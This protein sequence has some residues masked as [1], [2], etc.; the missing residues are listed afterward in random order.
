M[1]FNDTGTVLVTTAA[2]DS[3]NPVSFT[4]PY[5]FERARFDCTSGTPVSPSDFTCSVVDESDPLGS[6]IP[7]SQRPACQVTVT[8]FP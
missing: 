5:P 7:P 4:G 8:P 3:H 6:V 2:P 1:I